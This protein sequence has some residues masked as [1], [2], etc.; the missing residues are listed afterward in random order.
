M[1]KLRQIAHHIFVRLLCGTNFF[2]SGPTFG[3]SRSWSHDIKCRTTHVAHTVH[4]TK[5]TTHFMSHNHV[6]PGRTT[7]CSCPYGRTLTF[8]AITR[9]WFIFFGYCALVR[10]FISFPHMHC[11]LR[12]PTSFLSHPGTLLHGVQIILATLCTT[13]VCTLFTRRH[14]IGQYFLSDYILRS[15]TR[16]FFTYYF[17]MYSCRPLIR[18]Q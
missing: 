7:K 12:Y 2:W 14:V 15:R 18:T 17:F 5:T 8:F 11:G 13:I 10:V 9:Q 3:G 6:V 1:F 16:R 4:T